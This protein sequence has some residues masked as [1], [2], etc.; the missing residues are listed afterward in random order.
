MRDKKR[1]C[2]I[3]Q[4][5]TKMIG[6]FTERDLLT[7]VI[8][9]NLELSTPIDQVMTPNPSFLT[10]ESSI[11]E[12]IKLMSQKGYRHIPLV[13][14]QNEIQGFISV[15]DILDFLAEHFPYEVYSLPPDPHQINKTPEGA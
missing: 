12:A 2:A 10:L 4:Q 5:K 14:N 8:G 11:S 1:G 15:R 6:I 7:R 13:N 9:N 3:I